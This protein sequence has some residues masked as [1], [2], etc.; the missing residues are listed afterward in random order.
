MTDTQMDINVLFKAYEDEIGSL[1]GQLIRSEAVHNAQY[2]TLAQRAAR[3]EAILT[4]EQRE[5]LAAL[6]AAEA[7]ANGPQDVVPPNPGVPSSNR[8]ARRAQARK[9]TPAKKTAVAKKS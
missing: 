2:A 7:A 4:D 6:E 8:A 1:R 3:L 9:R 5:A